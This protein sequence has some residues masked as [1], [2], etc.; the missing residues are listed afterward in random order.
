MIRA[1]MRKNGTRNRAPSV[2]CHER[3][4]IAVMMRTSETPLLTTLERTVVKEA[5]TLPMSL[6]SH[7]HTVVSIGTVTT[8]SCSQ[9]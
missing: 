5:V 9:W 2:S 7:T 3:V 4:S 1:G 6:T 8:P